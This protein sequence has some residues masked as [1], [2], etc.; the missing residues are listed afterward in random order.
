MAPAKLG[1]S[2]AIT[3]VQVNSDLHLHQN[4]L[5]MTKGPGTYTSSL[6]YLY[7]PVRQIRKPAF[8]NGVL[9]KLFWFSMLLN[10]ILGGYGPDNKVILIINGCIAFP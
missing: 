4:V 2:N 3:N 6:K 5:H 8:A 9:V 7:F 10:T 1:P